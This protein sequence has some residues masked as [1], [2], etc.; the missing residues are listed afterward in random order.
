VY[1]ISDSIIPRVEEAISG[2]EVLQAVRDAIGYE[3]TPALIARQGGLVLSYMIAVSLPV[4][5]PEGHH[6]LYM[7]PLE[8]PHAPQEVVSQVIRELYRQAQAEADGIRVR[9]AI[10]GNG[11]K[12]TPGGLVT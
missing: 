1:R 9:H 6:V 4:P 11:H 2:L 10:P 5:G 7:Q 12:L 8:D 3:V